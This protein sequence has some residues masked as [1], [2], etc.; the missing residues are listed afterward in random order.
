MFQD[1]NLEAKS[2][3]R[4]LAKSRENLR[5]GIFGIACVR[6]DLTEST[7]VHPLCTGVN[8][9]IPLKIPFVINFFPD[10]NYDEGLKSEYCIFIKETRCQT[11]VEYKRECSTKIASLAK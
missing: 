5:H 2:H 1:H 8:E 6:Q 11:T 4:K 3:N 9:S 7:L 10:L